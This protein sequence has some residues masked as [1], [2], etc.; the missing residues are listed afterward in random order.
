MNILS[1]MYNA[2]WEFCKA[3]HSIVELGQLQSIT[4]R[5]DPSFLLSRTEE[6]QPHFLPPFNTTLTKTIIRLVKFI[7]AVLPLK[8]FA[9][10]IEFALIL[11]LIKTLFAE[12]VFISWW[13]I[14]NLTLLFPSW[15]TDRG[16]C[17][18]SQPIL[19]RILDS[20]VPQGRQKPYVKGTSATQKQSVPSAPDMKLLPFVCWAFFLSLIQK[21]IKFKNICLPSLTQRYKLHYTRRVQDVVKINYWRWENAFLKIFF[22]LLSSSKTR[23]ELFYVHRILLKE[24]TTKKKTQTGFDSP[25]G[26]LWH[27]IRFLPGQ[28]TLWNSVV[29]STGHALEIQGEI[30]GLEELKDLIR[31]EAAEMGCK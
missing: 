30:L 23:D 20:G 7:C 3:K 26:S 5:A 11:C 19:G 18:T 10:K 13:I 22:L 12:L 15:Q 28:G 31:S 6:I 8:N 16:C 24:T 2:G 21:R 25:K 9:I 29:T 1:R 14:V 4:P 17:F 27:C